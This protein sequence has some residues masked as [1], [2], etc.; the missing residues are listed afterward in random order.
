MGVGRWY[1]FSGGF[2]KKDD[3]G[4]SGVGGEGYWGLYRCL[5]L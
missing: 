2:G 4:M 5:K 3:L 1:V